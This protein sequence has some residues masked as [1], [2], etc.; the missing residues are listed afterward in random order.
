[1][2]I[3]HNATI[4]KRHCATGMWF[5][6]GNAFQR[7]L[8]DPNSFLWLNGFAGCGKSVLCS[9]AIQHTVRRR[10]DNP[11][12][13]GIAFFFFTFDD[14]SKRDCSA[15]LRALLLQLSE[16]HPECHASLVR[17]HRTY[18]PWVPLRE[19]LL[20]CLRSM[21]QRFGRVYIFLDALDESPRDK[22]RESVLDAVKTMQEWEIPGLH[23]L[24]TSRD[25]ADIRRV[26]RP[27]S[28]SYVSLKNDAVESDISI[29]IC[30][31]LKSNSDLQRWERYHDQIQ[32]ALLEHAQ[33]LV[34]NVECQFDSLKRCLR[35][36]AHLLACLRSLPHGLDESY[37]RMLCNIDRSLIND[38]RRILTLLCFTSRPLTVAELID[39]HAS[40][41]DGLAQ[42][43]LEDRRLDIESLID[44]CSGLLEI[45]SVLNSSSN[46]QTSQIVRIAHYSVQEYLESERIKEQK[47]AAFALEAQASHAAIAKICLAYLLEP[48]L[49]ETPLDEASAHEFPFASY[50]AKFWYQHYANAGSM[51]FECCGRFGTAL[52]AA[53]AGAQESIAHILL[54]K[55]ADVH[56]QGGELGN[57]L[58]AAALRGLKKVVHALLA[59]GSDPKTEGGEYGLPLQ[60]AAIAGNESVVRLLLDK[61]A[62]VNNHGGLYG[63]ALQAAL[64]FGHRGTARVLLQR[65]A[66]IYC[67]GGR[68][69]NVLQ[70]ACLGGLADMVEML[71]D[72]GIDVNIQGGK[73]GTALQGAAVRGHEAVIKLL[74]GK[75]ADVK[76]QGG[77]HGNA[78][79]AARYASHCEITGILHATGGVSAANI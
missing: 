9:T 34:R 14:E 66:D 41:M 42:F 46:S 43:T 44:I 23:F 3:N 8:T 21:A 22:H 38:A 75:N 30:D 33:G 25:E 53:C 67:Q 6:K 19:V 56:T 12:D 59:H 50:A 15:M 77:R 70:A 47:A 10:R 39:A 2:A 26:L 73:Y 78:L 69:G 55:G 61:G 4:A 40:D 11:A 37:E 79:E 32:E 58:Q 60:A 13:V 76:A 45:P 16:Q 29:Y 36:K 65:G 35:T 27:A 28:D 17:L 63:N 68:Y 20:E 74:L 48:Q 1:M 18:Q 5:I 57:A 62:D 31:I 64:S 71:L 49:S 72:R 51:G 24:V 54:A 52:Q 7:W